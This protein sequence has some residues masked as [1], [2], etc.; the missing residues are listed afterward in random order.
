MRR[1]TKPDFSDIMKMH[2][3]T[4]SNADYRNML[5]NIHLQ[6]YVESDNVNDLSQGGSV[7]KIIRNKYGIPVCFKVRCGGDIDY[8]SADRVTFWEPYDHYSSNEEYWDD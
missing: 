3:F 1:K 4:Q 6:C 8:I 7:E 2:G 5:D